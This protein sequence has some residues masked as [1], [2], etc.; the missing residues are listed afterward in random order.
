MA[1]NVQQIMDELGQKTSD[2]IAVFLEAQG[3]KGIPKKSLR[4][5]IAQYLYQQTHETVGVYSTSYINF[6][7]RGRP[8]ELFP[9]PVTPESVREFILLF[10]KGGYAQLRSEDD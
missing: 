10:D 5:P 2:E 3:V 9:D 8:G 7:A 1:D 4:C 6:D